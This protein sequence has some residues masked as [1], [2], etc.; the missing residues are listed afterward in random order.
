MQMKQSSIPTVLTIAGSDPI[1]GAG[2]QADLKTISAFHLYGM[3]VITAITAQNTQGVQAVYSLES[4]IVEKQLDSVFTDIMPDCV[5][6]GMLA[7]EEIVE[8]VAKKLRQYKPKKIVIDPIMVSSSGKEL[9][10][11]KGCNAM[12]EKLFPLAT[13]ITPNL[14]EAQFLAKRKEQEGLQ[15]GF[16]ETERQVIASL[17]EDTKKKAYWEMAEIIFSFFGNTIQKEQAILI[18]G[19]HM[20][21]LYA[22]DYLYCIEKNKRKESFFTSPRL[23]NPNTHGTGCTLSSAIAC[24]IA[25]GKTIEE[26]VRLAKEYITGAIRGGLYIGKGIGPLDHFWN[27]TLKIEC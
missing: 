2:I 18:K 22:E 27:R 15:Q 25:M 5:K 6:L 3:S 9:L 1:G 7:N 20:Q 8:A 21:G 11:P 10:E 19:G 24:G 16:M 12:I 14:P 13:I 23:D 4:E 17:T 26:S